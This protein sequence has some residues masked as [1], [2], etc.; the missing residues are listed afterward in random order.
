MPSDATTFPVP[1]GEGA[2]NVNGVCSLGAL[3]VTLPS[4]VTEF[5]GKVN[6]VL[7]LVALTIAL[8]VGDGIWM[9]NGV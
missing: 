3:T 8:A 6:G 2:G 7:R 9:V 4:V 5:A 1:E